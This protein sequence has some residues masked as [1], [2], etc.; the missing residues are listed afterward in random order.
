MAYFNSYMN[1]PA[2]RY[3]RDLCLREGVRRHYD[4]GDY[5]FRQGEVAI[6]LGYVLSGTLVYAVCG[7]DGVEHVVGLEYKGEFVSDFPFSI[8]GTQARTSVIAQTP[9]D[10]LCVPVKSLQERLSHDDELKDAIRITTEAVF[11]TLYDRHNALYTKTPE[12]RYLEL[13]DNDPQLFQHF[14]LKCIASYLN[15]TPT[16]LSKIRKKSVR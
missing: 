14:P 1:S 12:E 16:Y 10:I 13:I 7:A 15:V 11:G 8:S 9:C 4:R 6:Y 2:V 3:W 5:F